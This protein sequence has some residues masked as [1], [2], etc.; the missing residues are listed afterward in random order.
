MDFSIGKK[1]FH[2]IVNHGTAP[3][4]L[5]DGTPRW[6]PSYC[7]WYK[8]RMQHEIPFKTFQPGKRAYLFRFSTFS[9]NFPVD[10]PTK[11]FPSTAEPKFPE[12]STKWKAP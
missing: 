7:N 10:E 9:G 2:L 3:S 5:P 4:P 12:I 1:L 8:P 6:L 11:R